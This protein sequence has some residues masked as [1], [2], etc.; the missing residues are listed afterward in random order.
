MNENLKPVEKLTPFTKM[1][2]T[3]GTLPSSF[4]ASMSYYE[5]MVWLYEYLKNEIIPAVNN[6]GEAVEELQEKYIELKSYIDNYFENL[7]VQEEIN[8][9]LDE[10][11]ED[12]TLTALIKSYIDPI[13]EAFEQE[14]NNEIAEQEQNL[15]NAIENQNETI[16]GQNVEI[17]NFKSAVNSQIANINSKVETATSGSP[18]GVY[19]TVSDLETDDPDHDKIYLVLADGKWYYYDTGTSTWTAGGVYQASFVSDDSIDANMLVDNLKTS[20]H[21]E[22]PEHTNIEHY[23]IRMSNGSIYTANPYYISGP[24]HLNKG[25]IITFKGHVANGDNYIAVLSSIKYGA[26][27]DLGGANLFNPILSLADTDDHTITH[28]ATYE[29]DYYICLIGDPEDLIIY[30]NLYYQTNLNIK[31]NIEFVN[32]IIKNDTEDFTNGYYIT[33]GGGVYTSSQYKASNYIRID[34]LRKIVMRTNNNQLSINVNDVGMAFYDKEQNYISGVQYM[35]SEA[36]NICETTTPKGAYYVRFTLDKLMETGSYALYYNDLLDT[37]KKSSIDGSYRNV[38]SA[39]TNITCFG[40]SL[41]YSQVYKAS[42]NSRQAYITYP[43]HL[44]RICGN[45]VTPYAH[46]GDTAKQCWDRYGDNIASKTNQLTIIYL[47]TNNGLTDTIATDCA[48]NDY[49]TYSDNN[50]G[51]YGKLI[52][53]SLDAGSKVL[54]VKCYATS[55]NTTETTN[56]VID[57]FGTKFNV[58]VVDNERIADKIYHLGSGSYINNN[59]YN[60]LGYE[61]F[62]KQLIYNV[63]NLD[64]TMLKRILP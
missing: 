27:I 18:A 5:S 32:N 2:M 47:G 54:L 64:D 40:D 24:Y 7:D 25:D 6:N 42:D 45:T 1:I 63:S 50:T 37:I 46:A 51:C 11:A 36:T 17:Q 22:I 4:Y 8:I 38:L 34:E 33:G 56:D 3:I 20:L 48:G 53:K 44:Q 23:Y 30:R 58:A 49:T 59:H 12:G 16:Y 14:I 35:P 31:N 39:Y 10:M 60:D 52:K 21:Q 55:N 15:N 57:Q 13:Q 9:K 19:S 29:G 61:A 28:I 62:T 26:M 43:M 41:T